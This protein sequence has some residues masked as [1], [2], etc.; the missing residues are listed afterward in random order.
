MSISKTVALVV[1]LACHATVLAQSPPPAADQ[2]KHHHLHHHHGASAV[3][4]LAPARLVDRIVVQATTEEYAHVIGDMH[5]LLR[6]LGE[7]SAALASRDWSAVARV[8]GALT[9][10]KT[11]G[12]SDAAA[13]SFHAKIP[14]GWST[15]GAPM[16]LGFTRIAAEAAGEKRV[17]TVLTILSET[18]AQCA[19]CHA[20]FQIRKLDGH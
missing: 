18:T 9:P 2:H 4:L 14:A 11:M 5:K 12:S 16:H 13:V 17:D 3:N 20:R 8:A 10:E 6:S 19:G 7:I 15:Y 1:T